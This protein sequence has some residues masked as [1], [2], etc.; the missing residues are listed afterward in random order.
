MSFPKRPDDAVHA[1]QARNSRLRVVEEDDPPPLPPR[2]TD[3][4]SPADRRADNNGAKPPQ[5]RTLDPMPVP[6]LPPLDLSGRGRMLGMVVRLVVVVVGAGAIGA[7]GLVLLRTDFDS[8]LDMLRGNR[9]TQASVASAPRLVVRNQVAAVNERIALGVAVEPATP[10]A[11]V[12]IVGL[13]GGSQITAGQPSGTLGW[14]LS[15]Q[16]LA[17]VRIIPPRDFAGVVDLMVDLRKADDAVI[18]RRGVQLEWRAAPAAPPPAP[19]AAVTPAAPPPEKVAA[20]PPPAPQPMSA[21]SAPRDSNAAIPPADKA[22]DGEA[23]SLIKRGEELA[24]QGDFASA[25]L[26][27]QRAAEMRHAGAALALGATYD[28][29]VLRRLG[30]VGTVADPARA[31]QWYARA[32]EYGSAE[33]TQRLDALARESR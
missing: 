21:S 26:L 32:Q 11:S 10:G 4:E 28:P 1:G 9:A 33:A 15:A 29:V 25:R 5:W 27:L 18:D 22:S 16:D 23:E 31:R 6:P 19:I 14:R 8:V 30:V 20:P 12:V 7:G 24:Q 3:W 2:R 13:P 17:S